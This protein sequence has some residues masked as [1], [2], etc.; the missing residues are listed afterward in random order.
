M[1]LKDTLESLQ[2]QTPPG[3]VDVP[4]AY[5]F[6]ASGLTDGTSYQYLQKQID[7]DSDFI[8]RGISGTSLVAGTFRPYYYSRTEMFNALVR[9]V[10]NW[11]VLPEA[12]YPRNSQILFDLGVVARAFNV[13]NAEPHIYTSF[14]AFQGVRRYEAANF[15]IYRTPYDYREIPR[16]YQIVVQPGSAWTDAAAGIPTYPRTFQ[17][18]MLEGDFELMSIGVMDLTTMLPPVANPFW[19]RLYD[20]GGWFRFSDPGFNCFY[21]SATAP[22]VNA[23]PAVNK[24]Y[25]PN[26]P[27]PS[28]VYPEDGGIKFELQSLLPFASRNNAYQISFYGIHRQ[29][30]GAKA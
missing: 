3:K 25:R 11:P 29:R 8:L 17:V 24:W 10:A 6:D 12:F 14:I 15:P 7:N 30:N 20:A 16:H 13:A 1:S 28:T 21:W 27:A 4:Y 23:S 22:Q 18:P 19:M 9:T 2:Y 26:Y 5:V